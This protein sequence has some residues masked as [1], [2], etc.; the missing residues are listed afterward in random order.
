MGC[1]SS[2]TKMKHAVHVNPALPSS[3]IVEETKQQSSEKMK[4]QLPDSEKK[5]GRHNTTLG[6]PEAR[7]LGDAKKT[8]QDIQKSNDSADARLRDD[9]QMNTSST[10]QTSAMMNE[11]QNPS[12]SNIIHGAKYAALADWERVKEDHIVRLF[13]SSTFRD[14]QRER[15]SFFRYGEPRLRDWAK[16]KGLALD[17]IDLRWGLT[18]EVSSNGEVTIRCFES[19]EQCPYFL[20]TL[21][22][23]YGWIPDH[24]QPNEWHPNTDKRYP[25]L[26]DYESLSVTHYEIKYGALKNNPIARRAL[27][28]E[29][30]EE[31]A[32]ANTPDLTA[33]E[34][35][36]YQPVDQKDGL[37]QAAM[38][39][40][41]RKHFEVKK[42]QS[43]RQLTEIIVDDLI[44]I[45]DIDFWDF[46][47]ID[48]DEDLVHKQFL[49]HRL[50]GFE[51]RKELI[52]HL[53]SCVNTQLDRQT[54]HIT[55][56][57]AE[58]GVGKSSVMAALTRELKKDESLFV[59]YHFVG[60]SNL[61][62]YIESMNTRISRLIFES[63]ACLGALDREQ[64]RDLI[65][66]GL[67]EILKQAS[68]SMRFRT[69]ILVDAIN[70]L[71]DSPDHPHVN[72]LHWLPTTLPSNVA[73]VVSTIDTHPSCDAAKKSGLEIT[74]LYRLHANE[75]IQAAE[76]FMKKYD[77][78]LSEPQKELLLKNLINTGHPL[79]LRI[80]LDEMRTFGV[81]ETV[82]E[83]LACF[84]S[85][86]GVLELYDHVISRWESNYSSIQLSPQS[87]MVFEIVR[88]V[89][90]VLRISR[91]GLDDSELDDYI[92]YLLGR[93]LVGEEITSWKSF[94][95]K[96]IDS[97]FVRNGR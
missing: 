27:F 73:L 59:V 45:F 80:I 5:E 15:D 82:N 69:V 68:R 39:R 53:V 23:R 50:Q 12:S 90:S 13:L 62:Q 28:Y 57:G 89:M 54:S 87:P 49:H 66:K 96:L 94:F 43:A 19:I 35:L 24:S 86:K 64:E 76:S 1:G 56:I 74:P 22:S 84:L 31:Y 6:E 18:T 51:G 38:K 36:L 16:K 47:P 78:T 83:E 7:P 8:I 92:V 97:L 88:I 29:R 63:K 34:R 91:I 37:N 71:I 81:F 20:C 46:K 52:D 10:K 33:N 32:L 4:G 93:K 55:I 25:F 9:I 72:Q 60:C 77:K 2:S 40:E 65:K 42:Y 79:Y 44:A 11:K 75:V 21:G 17:F 85:T 67:G 30:D 58:S 26:R 14:M 70:Q 3:K 95:F 61:S 48:E 41:I